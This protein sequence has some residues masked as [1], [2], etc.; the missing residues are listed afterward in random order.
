MLTLNHKT[1]DRIEEIKLVGVWLT[2]WL[3]W[4]KNRREICKKTY[5]RLTMLTNLKYVC[6]DT[7]ELVQSITNVFFYAE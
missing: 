1:I 4:D 6:A 3:D 5:A 7:E 2:T